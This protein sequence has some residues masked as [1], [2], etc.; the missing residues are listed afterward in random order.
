MNG[1]ELAADVRDRLVASGPVSREALAGALHA[2]TPLAGD[3]GLLDRLDQVESALT[4]LG[5]LQSYAD[6]PAVTDV[7]VNGADQVWIERAGVLERAPVRFADD[8]EVRRLAQRLAVAAGRRL[9]D[10]QPWVDARLAGGCRL[11]AVLPPLAVDGPV[12]SLRLP[13]VQPFRLGELVAAGAMTPAVGRL[14]SLVVRRRAAFLVTGGTGT[15]KTTLL[16]ALLGECDPA[17]RVLLVEDLAELR[18]ELPHLV[19]LEARPANAEGAG[20]VT[21]QHLVRQAMRMRPDRLVVGEVRGAEMVDLLAALN[22]GHEGGCGTV[23]ATSAGSLPARLEA[24]G[25]AAGLPRAAV[26]SQLLAAV[27]LV[28][29]LRREEG[30]RTVAEIGLLAPGPDGLARVTSAVTRV[31]R[32]FRRGPAWP[33]LAGLLGIGEEPPC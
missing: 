11:H 13:R 18:P 31:D 10:A 9:D 20:A 23:H 5:L 15:G 21:V 30:L 26:H 27:Q 6:D 1:A 8:E 16:A 25:T 28:V 29:H 2:V 19:R 24:L 7:L 33:E 17:E 12:L 4:G 14:L 22:T 32:D 3:D